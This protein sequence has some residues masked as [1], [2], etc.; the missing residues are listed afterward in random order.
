MSTI[1]DPL[2]KY[3]KS[4]LHFININSTLRVIWYDQIPMLDSGD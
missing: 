2:C 1:R 4:Y 3:L